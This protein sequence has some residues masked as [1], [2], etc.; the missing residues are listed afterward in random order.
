MIVAFTPLQVKNTCKTLLMIE[1]NSLVK[2]T[3]KGKKPLGRK[4]L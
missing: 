4:Y 2:N 1:K 3:N